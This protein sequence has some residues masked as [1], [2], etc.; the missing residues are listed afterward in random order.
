MLSAYE[1]AAPGAAERILSEAE[2]Q[3][4][5]R[6]SLETTLVE[7]NVAWHKR[8]QISALL[9]AMTGLIGGMALVAFDKPT[10]GFGT[11]ITA[12]GGLVGLFA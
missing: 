8:G 6:R 10:L 7:A 5:H 2:N 12:V 9:V 3:A 4:A 1:E 11:V